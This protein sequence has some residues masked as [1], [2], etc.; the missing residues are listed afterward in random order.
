MESL[1]GL[2]QPL[3]AELDG[4]EAPLEVLQKTEVELA[5]GKYTVRFGGVAA[6]QGTYIANTA[7]KRA[8]LMLQGITGPNAGRTIPCIFKFLNET[9]MICYGLGGTRPISFSTETGSQRYLVTYA[10][11]PA[12]TG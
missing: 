10:R 9:L 12:S 2:W 7:G 8:E 1:E 6:D 5:D 4:E 11:K 3:Y